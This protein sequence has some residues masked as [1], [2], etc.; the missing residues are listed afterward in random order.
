MNKE[1][2]LDDAGNSVALFRSIFKAAIGH[3]LDTGH[4]PV[5]V[6]QEEMLNAA[7]RQ[8]EKDIW[9]FEHDGVSKN[10]VDHFEEVMLD[11][12]TDL[13]DCVGERADFKAIDSCLHELFS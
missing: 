3:L 7:E 10:D 4:D 8:K 6:S 11:Y 2:L 13:K 12:F 1:R 9:Y 5:A